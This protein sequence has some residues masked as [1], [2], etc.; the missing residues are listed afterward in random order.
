MKRITIFE[1]TDGSRWDS[2]EQCIERDRLDKRVRDIEATIP[3]VPKVASVCVHRHAMLVAKRKV[4]VM[5][6][7]LYPDHSVF[8]HDA[9]EIHPMSGAGRILDD[10]GGPLSRIWYL[11]MCWHDDRIYNQPYYARQAE[12]EAKP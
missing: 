7:E 2:V 4:V 1:A 11:F 9:D 6:R 12:G 3:E 5:C 10:C 8:Q